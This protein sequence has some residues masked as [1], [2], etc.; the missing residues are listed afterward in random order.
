MTATRAALVAR[1]RLYRKLDRPALPD[2]SL[3][4][5]PLELTWQ[6]TAQSFTL[7][8]LISNPEFGTG[9][10]GW[11]GVGATLTRIPPAGDGH[12]ARVGSWSG[13]ITPTGGT[14]ESYAVYGGPGDLLGTIPGRE[15]GAGAM[16]HQHAQAGPVAGDYRRL[17]V[18]AHTPGGLV[19]AGRTALFADTGS[20]TRFV[21]FTVPEDATGLEVRVY[22]G[23]S[24]TADETRFTMVTLYT[25][26]PYQATFDTVIS[27]SLANASYGPL[28]WWAGTPHASVSR[29]FH[30]TGLAWQRMTTD[31]LLSF[32]VRR[33]RQ[34]ATEV[35]QAGTLTFAYVVRDASDLTRIAVGD[36]VTMD[37][38]PAALMWLYGADDWTTHPD[39][40]GA[41][42]NYNRYTAFVVDAQLEYVTQGNGRPPLAVMRVTCSGPKARLGQT[43]LTEDSPFQPLPYTWDEPID[44]RLSRITVITNAQTFYGTQY[45]D[46]PPSS[47]EGAYE[48]GPLEAGVTALAAIE[49]YAAATGSNFSE[50]LQ[51]EGLGSIRWESLDA[52]AGKAP[53]VQLTADE[54]SDAVTWNQT[55]DGLVNVCRVEYG[56]EGARAAVEVRDTQ[57]IETF[58][59]YGATISTP[60]LEQAPAARLAGLTVGRNSRPRWRISRLELDLLDLAIPVDKARRL[61]RGEVG[62]LLEVVGMPGTAPA[63]RYY[64]LEGSEIEVT[65]H[66]WRLIV[67]VSSADQS[68]APLTWDD[69]PPAMTWGEVP[70][71][72]TWLGAA[73][74]FIQLPPAS[75]RW[76]D[77]PADL[78]WSDLAA[79]NAADNSLAVPTWE[80]YPNDP[81]P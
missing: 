38:T 18:Y 32:H 39:W 72:R 34:S 20:S 17:A 46:G 27:G 24:N 35:A 11:A 56:P 81:A 33:G 57:S 68:G 40:T 41:E 59:E 26:H 79:T 36:R 15:H 21:R 14:T 48:V 65:Q 1:S 16:V 22:S 62:E 13:V 50:S 73:G 45:I 23:S 49:D 60:L 43:V 42:N 37:H 3:L 76:A 19:L 44:D 51:L 28:Y 5:G 52:R 54:I 9:L 47:G 2:A 58:G 78:G 70:A 29:V 80:S 71:E 64:F 53:V 55:M 10:A 66:D 30:R 77:V 25:V 67:Y 6:T 8:N 75:F 61:W 69:M 4:E 7:D 12:D 63:D 74:W 31:R